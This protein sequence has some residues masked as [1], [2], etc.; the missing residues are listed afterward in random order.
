MPK[1]TAELVESIIHETEKLIIA[2]D[3]IKANLNTAETTKPTKKKPSK[4]KST[5]IED[6]SA[7][8]ADTPEPA[9]VA[10]PKTKRK[11][12]DYNLFIG[13]QIK[14]IGEDHKEVPVTE[15]MKMAQKLWKERKESLV[16]S[17]A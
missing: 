12:S 13:E 16:A 5:I 9:K 8:D 15:R 1:K 11:P 10:K 2:A 7:S 3:K 14:K 6:S 4:K 17:K